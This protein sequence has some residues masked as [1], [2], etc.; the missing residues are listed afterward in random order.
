MG[1][2]V[3]IV[4][5]AGIVVIGAVLVIAGAFPPNPSPQPVNHVLSNDRFQSH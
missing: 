3:L 5:L 2:V 1:K 4:V